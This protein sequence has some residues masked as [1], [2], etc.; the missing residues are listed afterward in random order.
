MTMRV[1]PATL[2][3]LP[4]VR[5]AYAHGRESQRALGAPEWPEFSDEAI[6]AEITVGRVM[7]VEDAGRLAGVFSMLEADP[8]LWGDLERGAHLY[9][10]RIAR[11]AGCRTPGLVAAIVEWAMAQCRVRGRAGVRMDTWASNEALISYYERLGFH[12]VGRRRIPPDARVPPHYHGL[13]LA[14]LERRLAD[15]EADGPAP[16]SPAATASHSSP[17]ADGRM[18]K[19]AGGLKA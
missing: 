7:R 9:L 15:H 5:A 16:R 1:E 18:S 8:V 14:L 19:A 13:E 17:R 10:H 12:R 3:D 4:A 11:T 6:A 2:V